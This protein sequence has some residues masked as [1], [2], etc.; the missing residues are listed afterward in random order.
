MGTHLRRALPILLGGLLLTGLAW[1]FTS[2]R[3][4]QE[5]NS[6][7]D[8]A[9]DASVAEITQ[10]MN[11]Y[12]EAL[13][14][15]G[16]LYA[17]SEDVTRTEFHRYVERLNIEERYPG[18]L[19]LEFARR[20]PLQAK[21][22][23]ER[24]VRQDSSQGSDYAKF[25][26]QPTGQRPEYMVT[27]YIEP[28]QRNV[29]A[30]GYDLLSESLRQ[31]AIEQSRDTGELTATA[32]LNLI[33]GGRPGV[34]FFI[35]IYQN[36][37]PLLTISQ[38]QEAFLGVVVAVFDTAALMAG[39]L[40]PATL[41]TL[42]IRI[43]DTNADHT[44]PASSTLIFDSSQLPHTMSRPMAATLHK[45]IM[46]ELGGRHWRI[47]IAALPTFGVQQGQT[48]PLFVL[49]G[50]V[51][52]SLL[53]FGTALSLVARR[54]ALRQADQL[55]AH[56]RDQEETL[57]LAAHVFDSSSE[58]IV[59]TDAN[60]RI[61]A[62]NKA[63]TE[64]TGY[65]REE[66]LGQNPRLFQSHWQDRDFYEG[67]WHA[68]RSDGHWEGEI[69]D[70][71]KDGSLYAQWLTIN[72]NRD[73]AGQI[74]H[75]VGIC[76]DITERK[77]TQ[78]RIQHLAY[79]D[80]LTDLPNRLLLQDRI[81]LAIAEAQRDK[82][83][84]AVLFMDLDR[85]KTINDSLGHLVGD[86]LLQQVAQRLASCLHEADTI[87]RIGG[88]E[89]VI[90]LPNIAE[91]SKV[92]DIA[93]DILKALSAPVLV[94]GRTFHTS[95]SIGI[96]LYPN[97]GQDVQTLMKYA[98]TAMYH[99]KENGRNNFQFFTPQLNLWA[100]ERLAMENDLRL[101]LERSEF[102]IHY[103]P[104]VD[105][106]SGRV[107]GLEALLRWQHPE[108][109]MLLPNR[110][111]PTAEETGLIIPL[112]EWVLRSVCSQ[113]VLWQQQ[114]L[115]PLPIAV[116]LS[117]VQFRQADLV[118]SISR[119]LDSTGLPPQF[120][121]LELTES[122]L[123]QQSAPNTAMLERFSSMGIKLSIDDFGTGYSSLSYLKRFPI[124]RLKID[125]SFVRDI[126]TDSED[127]AIVTAIIALAHSLEIEV[128]AEGVETRQQRDFL[129]RQGCYLYQGYLCARPM[130]AE[131]VAAYLQQIA[132]PTEMRFNPMA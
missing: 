106:I 56:L 13:R 17:A 117:A 50:G 75:Y 80:P 15:V 111:I 40:H 55:T 46:F 91:T 24:Q 1:H 48:P 14:G 82:T 9:A 33:Q 37:A 89:Y 44:R 95:A 100:S 69:W 29:G 88:D 59:F 79:H 7:F 104:Q 96:S 113:G 11:I 64:I 83:M 108:K 71:R 122:M 10:L 36:G 19:A 51:A 31:Q 23:Y 27:E 118:Q 30:L 129:Y 81:G 70:R 109:G 76:T 22:T 90:V 94:E 124:D 115:Q 18:I 107:V 2:S 92:A 127:A 86:K 87:S 93:H 6:A 20:V 25:E 41:N 63:Y 58:G 85:F 131:D 16:S 105:A 32:P 8:A 67:M 52:I 72:A 101:A 103:Q 65:S 125:Q 121:E 12:M 132:T 77:Q 102:L 126:T 98:D 39:A 97:D 26:I 43:F 119:T 123:M 57:R 128:I 68:L 114:G 110:F 78:E 61:V 74:S 130:P 60:T 99:A 54:A 116:N 38:R 66:I 34:L 49:M 3:I 120:L 28:I 42:A 73:E 45:Q 4:N 62:V 112:G 47:E 84:I 21:T 35:P 53:L 5:V